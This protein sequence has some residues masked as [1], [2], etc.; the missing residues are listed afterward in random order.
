MDGQFRGA[1]DSD[2]QPHPPNYSTRVPD[3]TPSLNET[4]TQKLKDADDPHK[5]PSVRDGKKI[6]KSLLLLLGMGWGR[7]PTW[8]RRR[9]R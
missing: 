3:P 1:D 2:R 8:R 6:K 7:G 5:K 4:G 9:R